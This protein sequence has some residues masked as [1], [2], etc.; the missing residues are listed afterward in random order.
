MK[1]KSGL[2]LSLGISGIAIFWGLPLLIVM[3][4]PMTLW[5][6]TLQG[7][8]YAMGIFVLYAI[9]LILLWRLTG[10]LKFKKTP[11]PENTD[12]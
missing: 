4:L 6:N 3:N 8:I 1:K 7:Y 10:Y 9:V 11:E 5:N 2:I 12:A